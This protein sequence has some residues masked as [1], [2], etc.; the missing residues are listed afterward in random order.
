MKSRIC[1]TL[2]ALLMIGLLACALPLTVP[3]L[4]G[5]QIYSVLTFS[6]TPALPVGCAVYVKACDP[7]ALQAG[8]I[9]TYSLG[10]GSTVTETHRVVSNDVNSAKLVTK[11]DANAQADVYPVGYDRVI[12]R[13]EY[14]IPYWGRMA[15]AL[16]QPSGI[17][18]CAAI[19]AL[20]L[21]L[22]TVADRGKSK[23]GNTARQDP[24]KKA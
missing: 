19:F 6:M 21:V 10:T 9:V 17:A 14:S 18:I 5:Y 22:W 2:A 8:D 7:A 12:G 11:G 23:R 13:V 20:A 1:S 24:A 4:L 3:K 15:T 16:R